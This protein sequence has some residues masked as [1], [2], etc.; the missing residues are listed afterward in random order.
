MKYYTLG[1]I[2]LLFSLVTILTSFHYINLVQPLERKIENIQSNINFLQDKI[3]INE[4]EYTALLSPGYLEKLEKI[5]FS[6]NYYED[7]NLKIVGINKNSIKDLRKV[8]RVTSN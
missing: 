6:N 3:K 1:I 2:F 8:I 4:L 5:Y 7:T